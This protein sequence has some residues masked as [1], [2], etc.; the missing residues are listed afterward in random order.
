VQLLSAFH[1]QTKEGEY[2]NMES[3]QDR[4]GL[5]AYTKA[6]SLRQRGLLEVTKC[7]WCP[8]YLDH[9]HQHQWVRGELC[10]HHNNRMKQI[11][12]RTHSLRAAQ[13]WQISQFLRCPE[14][15]KVLEGHP[16]E[17]QADAVAQLNRVIRHFP[18]F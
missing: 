6:L 2:H 3:F 7:E 12:A 17:T 18:A 10:P 11:D 15:R 4:Y 16:A 8:T 14:C 9:C 13:A 1:T 5:M